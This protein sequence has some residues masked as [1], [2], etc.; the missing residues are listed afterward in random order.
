MARHNV[1]AAFHERT[2][3]TMLAAIRYADGAGVPAVWLTTGG[4]SDAMIVF[5]AVAAVTQRIR[6][7]TA[8]VPT[9][10]RHPIVVAQ[11]AADKT[12]A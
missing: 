7:G 2:A 8:I 3:A 6:M 12:C 9:Y 5:A 10:P 4:G 11:H 1:G